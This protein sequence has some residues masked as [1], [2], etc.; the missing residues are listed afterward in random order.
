MIWDHC[1]KVAFYAREIAFSY[2]QT[3]IIESVYMAGLL[4][5]LGKIV[6]LATDKKLVRKIASIVKDRKITTTTMEE[7]SI[8]ISHSAIGALIAQKWNFPESLVE[9]IKFHHAPYNA[10]TKYSDVVNIIYLA[11]MMIGIEDRRYNYYYIDEA[12]LE[13]Y[14]LLDINKFNTYHERLKNKYESNKFT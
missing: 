11:N 14:D 13:R 2:R 6:L 1:N 8:G 4:H 9:A 5:D 12:M 3:S 7:I 10:A